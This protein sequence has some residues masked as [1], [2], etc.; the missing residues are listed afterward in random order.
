MLFDVAIAAK[1]R[2]RSD[3]DTSS[4]PEYVSS[5]W[6]Y[7]GEQ[8]TEHEDKTNAGKKSGVQMMRNNYR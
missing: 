7:I 1:L 3:S 2:P 8:F 5:R 4:G 6:H